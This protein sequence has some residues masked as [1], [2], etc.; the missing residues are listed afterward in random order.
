[1]KIIRADINDVPAL[2]ETR[3]DNEK[4]F[5]NMDYLETCK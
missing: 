3:E 5:A 2:F 4:D 1:M